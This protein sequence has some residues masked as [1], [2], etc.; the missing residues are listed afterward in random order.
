MIILNLVLFGTGTFLRIE[1]RGVGGGLTPPQ[2]H[3][4]IS[5]CR[6]SLKEGDALL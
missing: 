1:D 5:I 6:V 4:P 3:S 2:A